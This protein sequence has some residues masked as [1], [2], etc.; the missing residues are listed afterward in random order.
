M[1]QDSVEPIKLQNAV[2]LVRETLT[3]TIIDGSLAPGER[4]VE[5]QLARSMDISRG[6]L[7]EACRL[8]EQ[9]GLLES[10][11]RRGFFVKGFDANT[12]SNLM[13][14]RIA[15]QVEAARLAARRMNDGDMQ[16]MHRRFHEVKALVER[17]EDIETTLEASLHFHRL[18]F[19]LT[20]NPRL[21]RA[22]D[23]LLP[24]SRL[25][26]CYCNRHEEDQTGDSNAFYLEHLPAVI[27]AFETRDPDK[28]AAAMRHY[29]E[30]LHESHLF[31]L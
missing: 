8:L 19:E 2:D 6:P 7:R 13:E 3:K 25:I 29:L 14:L 16:E 10:K 24:D 28:S 1:A 31:Y 26:A 11:P 5:V 4:I 23:D 22:F 21:L 15:L 17:G 12:I 20:G 9:Q 18:I 30:Q 27:A